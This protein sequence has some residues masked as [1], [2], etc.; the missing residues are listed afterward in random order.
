[1]EIDKASAA[2]FG[3]PRFGSFGQAVHGLTERAVTHTHTNK[4]TYTQKLYL[5]TEW[6]V[7]HTP[8]NKQIYTQKLHLPMKVLNKENKNV[9]NIFVLWY[10]T[11]ESKT[12]PTN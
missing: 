7:T 5:Q 1:M 4:Q 2:E 12:T 9:V 8:T 6:A 10:A 3:R 11:M